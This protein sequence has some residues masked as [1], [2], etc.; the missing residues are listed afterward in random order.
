MAIFIKLQNIKIIKSLAHIKTYY[1]IVYRHSN[2]SF[3]YTLS[4]KRT[5]LFVLFFIDMILFYKENNHDKTH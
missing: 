2:V 5:L 4:I 1:Y 3:T